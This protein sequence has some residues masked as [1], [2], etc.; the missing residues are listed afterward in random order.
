MPSFRTCICSA[1]LHQ[2]QTGVST[3]TK[4]EGEDEEKNDD[5]V[6][7]S[8]GSAKVVKNTATKA[9]VVSEKETKNAGGKAFSQFRYD[10]H[11]PKHTMPFHFMTVSKNYGNGGYFETRSIKCLSKKLVFSS[12]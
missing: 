8:S 6:D 5:V 2:K 11:C 1:E 12:L 9:K 3:P 7:F 10:H 4:K